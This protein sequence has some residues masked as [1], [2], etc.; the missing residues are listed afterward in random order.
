MIFAPAIGSMIYRVTTT[1]QQSMYYLVVLSSI[2]MVFIFGSGV[3]AGTA[4]VIKDNEEKREMRFV[5][6][7]LV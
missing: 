2:A 5:I 6:K 4:L 7:K 1:E 3:Q